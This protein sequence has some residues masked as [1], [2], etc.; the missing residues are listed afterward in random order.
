MKNCDQ[1]HSLAKITCT[2]GRT[3]AV[4]LFGN[5]NSLSYQFEA[6]APGAQPAILSEY[7]VAVRDHYN[8]VFEDTRPFFVATLA[9][10][11][12]PVYATVAS[13]SVQNALC[14]DTDLSL[15]PDPKLT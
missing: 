15:G 8:R 4:Y 6:S 5:S 11:T 14:P 3:W 7:A 9:G 1:T 10:E 12:I 2:L 13:Y